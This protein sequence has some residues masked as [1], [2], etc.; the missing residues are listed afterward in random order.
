[1]KRF[2]TILLLLGSVFVTGPALSHGT[3]D[4]IRKNPA[5]AY[6]CGPTDCAPLPDNQVIVTSNGW[7]V[8]PNRQRFKLTDPNVFPSNDNHYWACR[9]TG[10]PYRCFFYPNLSS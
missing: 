7:V 8:L 3:A 9:P 6:C 1:M 10:E 4:W 2:A 5:T